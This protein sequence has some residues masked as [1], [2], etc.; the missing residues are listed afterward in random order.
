MPAPMMPGRRIGNSMSQKRRQG[1]APRSSAASSRRRSKRVAI[2][3]TSSSANGSAQTMCAM[4]I[5]HMPSRRPSSERKKMNSAAPMVRPGTNS[6]SSAIS[7]TPPG[8]PMRGI[9]RPTAVAAS[10][11][12]SPT[13]RPSTVLSIRGSTH[14]GS[15]SRLA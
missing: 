1:L 10:M 14:C 9:A 12:Q 6:G 8:R 7:T 11:Q 2:T 13:I 5:D 3:S 15:S 4:K